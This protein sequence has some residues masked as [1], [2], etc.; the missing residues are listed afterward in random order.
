MEG[1]TTTCPTPA[2]GRALACI[3]N[4]QA[5]PF[6][7]QWVTITRQEH[8]D[9]KWRAGYWETQHA[10]VKS[11]LEEVRQDNLVKDAKI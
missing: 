10:R 6:S 7:Q 4:G 1:T 5:S 11:Q 3:D 2:P 9:L 8:I